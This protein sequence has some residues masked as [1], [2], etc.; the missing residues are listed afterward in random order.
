MENLYLVCDGI[1]TEL[2]YPIDFDGE[3]SVLALADSEGEAL[4]LAGE[5]DRGELM[6]DNWEW[7]GQTVAAL[8]D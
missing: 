5:Y 4:R 1:A 3:T 8:R 2:A 7:N 6:Y